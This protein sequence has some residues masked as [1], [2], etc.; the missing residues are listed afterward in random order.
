MAKST[1]WQLNHA[2]S[3]YRFQSRQD[4]G[5]KIIYSV[6]IER[7]A[8][9]TVGRPLEAEEDQT[10]TNLRYSD[11]RQIR[12]HFVD[13]EDRDA[14][15]LQK[16]WMDTLHR[17]EQRYDE[18]YTLL[19]KD[20]TSEDVDNVWDFFPRMHRNED[21]YTIADYSDLPELV[22]EYIQR[23]HP[24]SELYAEVYLL[25]VQGYSSFEISE[26]LGKPQSMICTALKVA[27]QN[28]QEYRLLYFDEGDRVYPQPVPD[29]RAHP[30]RRGAAANNEA[31]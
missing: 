11:G 29:H 17:R 3:T 31:R 5:E 20:G 14:A 28:A 6:P 13:L 8:D 16:R 27:M 25:Q 12:V 7:P 30:S 4:E 18:R 9:A 26:K 24:K 19:K 2:D 22:A 10:F 23:R 1:N 21:G 15:M